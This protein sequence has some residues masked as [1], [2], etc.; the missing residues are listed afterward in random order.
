VDHLSA[1]GGGQFPTGAN[2]GDAVVWSELAG[3]IHQQ[4][5]EENRR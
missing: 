1:G 3:F 5:L 2:V 4:W